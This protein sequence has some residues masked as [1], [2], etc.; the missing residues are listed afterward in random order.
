MVNETILKLTF[1]LKLSM[2][3]WSSHFCVRMGT[4]CLKG[5]LKLQYEH[6]EKKITRYVAPGK[7]MPV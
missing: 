7:N 1:F 6:L 5:K 3:Q 4:Q 2:N